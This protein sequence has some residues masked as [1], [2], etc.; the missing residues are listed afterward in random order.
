V[1]PLAQFS[2]HSPARTHQIDD[3]DKRSDD[4]EK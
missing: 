4:P 2:V 1:T 3:G